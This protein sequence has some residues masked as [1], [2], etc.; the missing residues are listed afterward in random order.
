MSPKKKTRRERKI[1]KKKG[2]GFS[3]LQGSKKHIIL[4]TII[5]VT[6]VLCFVNECK[7]YVIFAY[8]FNVVF[9]L[10]FVNELIPAEGLICNPLAV[11]CFCPLYRI[12]HL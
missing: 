3:R 10:R 12:K 4:D 5:N 1:R 11:V 9:V 7:R 8:V 2:V 6:L